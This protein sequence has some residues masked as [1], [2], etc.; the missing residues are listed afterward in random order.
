MWKTG[1]D[2]TVENL[3]RDENGALDFA[4]NMGDEVQYI[5]KG[6]KCNYNGKEV[7]CLTFGSESGGIIGKK[8]GPDVG[9]F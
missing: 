1:I 9:T 3:A 5:P 7:T 2:I 6:P 8:S 4:L